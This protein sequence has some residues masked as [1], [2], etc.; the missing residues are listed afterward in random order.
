MTWGIILA[1]LANVIIGVVW[2]LPAVFGKQW[3]VLAGI[4]PNVPQKGQAKGFVV[5]II[6]ALVASLVLAMFVSGLKA[7]TII[8]GAISGFFAWLGFIATSQL[9]DTIFSRKPLKLFVI[10]A[11]F[12]LVAIV[13]MGAILAGLS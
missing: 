5:M 8:K 7:D 10:T 9:T 2:Y 6:S 1:A 12:H 11:G 4:D 3:M 13:V